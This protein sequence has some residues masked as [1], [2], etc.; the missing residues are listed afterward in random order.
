MASPRRLAATFV[1]ALAALCAGGG[2]AVAEPEPTTPATPSVRTGPTI[3]RGLDNETVSLTLTP[4]EGPPG[5]EV[6]MRATGYWACLQTEG[7]SSTESS[8][9]PWALRLTWAGNPIAASQNTL[10]G[11]D[12]VASYV[13]PDDATGDQVVEASCEGFQPSTATFSVEQTVSPTLEVNPTTA[14]RGSRIEATGADFNC[15][16]GAVELSWEGGGP[17]IDEAPSPSFTASIAIPDDMSP[18][19][20]V[21]VAQCQGDTA[22]PLRQPIEV[23]EPAVTSSPV[24]SSPIVTTPPVTTSPAVGPPSTSSVQPTGGNPVPTT[25]VITTRRPEPVRVDLTGWLL[26]LVLLV[27]AGLIARH[28]Y[29]RRD[30]HPEPAADLRVVAH[31]DGSGRVTVDEVPGYGETTHAIRLETRYDPGI[32]LIQEVLDDHTHAQ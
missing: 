24:V 4:E 15:E 30:S 22:A 10:Q 27:I 17:P 29:R 14:D 5:T 25:E 18:G 16:S 6:S 20:H 21:L 3:L 31:A 12:V 7:T 9:S 28:A 1:T 19:P 13:V 11:L 8:V 23:T 26:V 2:I 32:P